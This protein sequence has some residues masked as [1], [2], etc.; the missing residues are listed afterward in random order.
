MAPRTDRRLAKRAAQRVRSETA[1]PQI[2]QALL[3]S[4]GTQSDRAAGTAIFEQGQP[5]LHVYYIVDGRIHISVTSKQGKEGV[6]AV[7]LSPGDFFGESALTAQRLYLATATVAS[8]A[9]I[10]QISRERMADALRVNEM[11]AAAFTAYL[12]QR[13]LD[14]QAELVDHL[15]NSSE[16]RLARTLL[17]LANFGQEGKLAPIANMTQDLLAQ[18]VGT[19][20]GRISFF[21]NKFRRLGLIDYNGTITVHSGLLSVVLHD[22]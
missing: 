11:V 1:H 5:S 16:K 3:G 14:I 10:I 18:R 4:G 9:R 12:L 19:T 13:S 7:P 17:L 21:M 6:I 15:F 22:E 20:R 8:D 2:S